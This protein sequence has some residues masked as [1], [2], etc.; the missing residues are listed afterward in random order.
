MAVERGVYNMGIQFIISIML[1]TIE[2]VV[3]PAQ[4]G[5]GAA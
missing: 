2:S 5:G 1:Q 3:V 4:V